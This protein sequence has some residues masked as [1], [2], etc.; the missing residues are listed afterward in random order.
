MVRGID[1]NAVF[2][3][4]PDLMPPGYHESVEAARL[5]QIEKKAKA[6]AERESKK[7]KPRG[8]KKTR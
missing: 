2:R 4:R 1:W 7:R 8:G 5:Y 3:E 6:A